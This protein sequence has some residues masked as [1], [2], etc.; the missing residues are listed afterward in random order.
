MA[1]EKAQKADDSGTGSSLSSSSKRKRSS[2]N[3]GSGVSS[4]APAKPFRPLSTLF[5]PPAS[6]NTS[7]VAASSSTSQSPK[8]SKRKVASAKSKEVSASSSKSKTAEAAIELSSDDDV[9]V[10]DSF[11][12][13]KALSDSDDEGKDDDD[14]VLTGFQPAVKTTSS[15]RKSGKTHQ[16]SA[17]PA[18][19][20]TNVVKQN[21][22]ETSKLSAKS[23][24][25]QREIV[26]DNRIVELDIHD[27]TASKPND[28]H[29]LCLLVVTND[30]PTRRTLV[31]EVLAFGFRLALCS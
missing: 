17:V 3:S 11:D 18:T 5:G 19:Q 26:D 24:G 8:A 13:I 7:S 2:A 25:K 10:D 4:A 12:G 20:T 30:I 14:L 31:G 22:N 15:T 28:N 21:G 27:S 9:I 29:Q 16:T 1:R 23:K 6:S